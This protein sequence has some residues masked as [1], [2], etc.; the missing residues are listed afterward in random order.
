MVRRKLPLLED[1]PFSPTSFARDHSSKEYGTIV[2]VRIMCI[3]PV[4]LIELYQKLTVNRN[5]VC[6]YCPS[7]SEYARLAYIRY[8]VI[9]ASL[10]TWER[11]R[12]CNEYS[13]WPY[14]NKP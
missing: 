13:A 9:V 4:L 2:K 7:C 8:G 11:L 3:I 5:H 14:R 12:N 10:M 6:N 1:V